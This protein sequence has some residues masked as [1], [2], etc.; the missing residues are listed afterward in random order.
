MPLAENGATIKNKK[1]RE[2]V[3]VH[4]S[5]ISGLEE[6]CQVGGRRQNV[7]IVYVGKKHL[8]A[9]CDAVAG[10]SGCVAASV[11][12]HC[13]SDMS[14]VPLFVQHVSAGNSA[15]A[16]GARQKIVV[17]DNAGICDFSVVVEEA[18]VHVDACVGHADNGLRHVDV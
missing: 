3:D 5:I 4:S 9:D 13:A 10:F 15:A 16:H 8:G 14:A 17:V 2:E 7:F 12:A 11:A 18:V 6:I 1:G